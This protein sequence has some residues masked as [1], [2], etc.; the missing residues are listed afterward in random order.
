MIN[1]LVIV[2]EAITMWLCLHIAFGEKI[3]RTKGEALFFVVYIPVFIFCSFGVFIEVLYFLL[4]VFIAVWCKLLFKRKCISVIMRSIAGIV[5]VG[6]D[7]T[8]VMF[9]YA[10]VTSELKLSVELDC[11]IACSMVLLIAFLFYKFVVEKKRII[12]KELGDKNILILIVFIAVFLFYVK[13]EFE[14]NRTIPIIYVFFFTMLA[15]VFMYL[16][17]KQKDIYELEKKNLNFELQ[18]MYGSAYEELLREVRR[19]QHDYKNQLTAIYS[20]H[21]TA[22]SLE[23][24]KIMQEEYLGI[25]ENEGEYDYILTKCNNAI[26]AGYLYNAC[27][28]MKSD[29]IRLNVDIMLTENNIDI[30]TKYI[31]EILGILLTNASEYLAKND[32]FEKFINLKLHQKNDG[33]IIEVSNPSEYISYEKI[34]K[35]FEKGY[36]TKGTNRGIGLF[37][38]KN[39]VDNRKGKLQVENINVNEKNLLLFSLNI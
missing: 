36:S 9:I 29:N 5:A 37:S 24:L 13:L 4:W 2:M 28:K 3:K 16:C 7:E 6:V 32:E 12:N 26:I 39:I 17:K 8:I 15:V 20:M 23:E 22:K 27:V 18:S 25:I 35:M 33:I 31:V 21:A 10:I 19:R 14:V 1:V 38:L 30:K 34:S 11:M